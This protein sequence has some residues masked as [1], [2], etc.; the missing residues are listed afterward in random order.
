MRNTD[1]LAVRAYVTAQDNTTSTL[2]PDQLL[3]DMTHSNLEQRHIEI[4]IDKHTAVTEIY[5][6]FH[7]KTGSLVD[8]QTL[9]LFEQE[10]L[11]VAALPAYN[12]PEARRPIAYF[13]SVTSTTTTTTTTTTS[14]RIHCVD[15]NPHSISANRALE[16]TNLVEK[17]VMSDDDY[18]KR[19][20]GT[21]RSWARA[22]Q[23]VDP[24]FS[25]TKHAQEHAIRQEAI[26]C[27]KLG[28]PLPDGVVLKNDENGRIE[29]VVV[30]ATEENQQEDTFDDPNSVAHC[31]VGGRCQIQP[32]KRRGRV[33]WVGSIPDHR[34]SND[35]NN[36]NKQSVSYWVGV[37]LDEPVGQNDGTFFKT[38]Q[39]YFEAEPKY[40]A[41][42]R[43][44]NVET[45]EFPERD[46]MDDSS[47]D[48]EDEL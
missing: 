47:S 33:A 25:L 7:Q 16:D 8:D 1:L 21:L 42:C 43:G 4:R 44:R 46:I 32:G 6:L 40:G 27:Y 13:L 5:H 29:F 12:D 11:S 23:Q 17:Y 2:H 37:I 38:G 20:T 26:R 31:H 30:V 22:Q 15:H 45:G 14:I 48:E 3:V 35:N 19:Q 39:R 36:N 9:Q 24:N 28:L 18:D 34:D 10:C 41:Y